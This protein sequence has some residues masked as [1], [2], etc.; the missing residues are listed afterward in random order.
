[1]S[2]F[3]SFFLLL[4]LLA[5]GIDLFE[6]VTKVIWNSS[7]KSHYKISMKIR[8]GDTFLFMYDYIMVLI[9]RI[10]AWDLLELR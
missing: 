7:Q 9:K 4:L 1:M 6:F 10:R 2:N 8:L 3:F 5:Y